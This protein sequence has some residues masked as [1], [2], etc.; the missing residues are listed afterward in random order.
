M[1]GRQSFRECIAD[2]L[3]GKGYG[4]KRLKEV[5][6]RFEYHAKVNDAQ[7]IA[8]P[9]ADTMAMKSVMDEIEY[10]MREKVK[11]AMK[12]VA[13]AADI[14]DTVTQGY[15]IR[16]SVLVGDGKMGNGVGVGLARA[17]ISMLQHD[18]RIKGMD[19]TSLEHSY[20]NKWWFLMNH[21]LD[22]FSYGTFG[23]Q[24]GVAHFPN[25]IRE[26]TGRNT[27]DVAAKEIAAAIKKVTDTVV[28]DM[29]KAG[30]SIRRLTDFVLPQRQNAAKIV[31]AGVKA[32]SDHMNELL[33]WGRM[34]WPNGDLIE[35]SER[36]ALLGE[37][38]STLRSDG[39]VRINPNSFSGR[40]S[41]IGNSLDNHRFM[42]FKDGDAWLKMHELYGDGTVLDV[43]SSYIDTMARR[44]A[45][46]Q[47][48][49]PNPS[50][51]MARIQA[52]V[53]LQAGIAENTADR[54]GGKKRD[55]QAV[56]DAN[57]VMKNRF[58]PMFDIITHKNP[59]DPESMMGLT[60]VTTTNILA[61]AQLGGMIFAAMGGDFV[62]TLAKRMLNHM[63]LTD[64]IGSYVYNMALPGSYGNIERIAARAGYI[65]DET[66]SGMYAMSRFIGP[67]AEGAVWAK[68]IGDVAMR[69]TLIN[70]HTN[71]ARWG[72]ARSMMGAL[73]EFRAK[74][75]DEIP[76]KFVLER[77]GITARDWDVVR[78]LPSS[79]GPAG[80]TWL[81][82]TDILRSNLIDKDQ[83]YR[84][85]FT[86]IDA[87]ARTMVPGATL[88]ASIVLKGTTRPDTLLGVIAHSFSMYKNFP[89]T[90]A[91][92]YG[93]EILARDVS[94]MRRV[95]FIA[96]LG[97]GSVAVGATAIQMKEIA[98]GR[99]PLPMDTA[100]FW[101]KAFMAGGGASIWGDFL[102]GG[103]NA[104]RG[105]PAEIAGGP[106][107]GLGSDMTNLAF[108]DSFAWA[109]AFDQG[110]DWSAKFPARL[111][112]AI[113]R[114]TPGTSL[115]WS[116]LVLEREVWDRLQAVADPK[117][118][119]KWRRKV[120][121]QQREMGNTYYWPPGETLSGDRL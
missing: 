5:I 33:D 30:G 20:K 106:L 117:A 59:M 94:K 96:A 47:K 98:K 104:Q 42:I 77:Y 39:A 75:F 55:K 109:R 8:H 36:T 105:G 32:W 99:T 112:E 84:K 79:N 3:K 7:G 102:F 82:P 9:T 22:N 91:Q 51:G 88:E 97:L 26:L 53:R 56:I 81:A 35:P 34:R 107:A 100:A 19:V 16:T 87:E 83:L 1:F 89:L 58:N 48:F 86:F 67:S 23:R 45:L 114:N 113:K 18:G 28:D 121:K 25:I 41:A 64:G 52:E 101:G 71:L 40:G 115:W 60:A 119:Q 85:F 110:E 62:Q 61:P 6:E 49:G 44:T 103:V 21:V 108:G 15:G 57:A 120:R 12:E 38:Y 68:R 76:F 118:R 46:V 27:G 10:E 63:R 69:A 50:M 54:V 17:A 66:T 72:A 70:R 65:F 73:D 92:T 37:L 78:K 14:R 93:R 11:R 31:K 90:F 43:F 4:E 2:N 116:R 80:T 95:G 111:T 13:V 74:G 29:N 24:R